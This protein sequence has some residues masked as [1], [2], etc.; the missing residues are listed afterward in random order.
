LRAARSAALAS[1]SQ[2]IST[3]R[4]TLLERAGHIAGPII[5]A[6][7]FLF[8]GQDATV[9]I[10]IGGFVACLGLLFVA[11]NVQPPVRQSAIRGRAM[12]AQLG[13]QRRPA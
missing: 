9:L 12:S 2:A 7:V 5:I 11:Q 10:R 3:Q 4:S 8:F 6:Q 1:L 13:V